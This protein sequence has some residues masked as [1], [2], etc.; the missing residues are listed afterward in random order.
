VAEQQKK[1]ADRLNS[2]PIS[3]DKMQLYWEMAGG[4]RLAKYGDFL[5][6]D[7]IANQYNY[8]HQEV[9][10]LTWDEVLTIIVLNREKSYTEHLAHSLKRAAK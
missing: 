1:W 8:T 7:Q 4:E 10:L 9:F 3:D 2:L 6:I 5:F